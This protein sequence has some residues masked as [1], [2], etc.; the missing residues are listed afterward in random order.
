MAGHEHHPSALQ[1]PPGVAG[2]RTVRTDTHAHQ[3]RERA[4][5][6][7]QLAARTFPF[8]TDWGS[9]VRGAAAARTLYR[10]ILTAQERT[11]RPDHPNT[12]ILPADCL[13]LSMLPRARI[14]W[15]LATDTD[16]P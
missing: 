5:E 8:S 6:I 7:D 16:Q 14:I 3:M 13:P 11:L 2:W 4:S 12:L 1:G 9:S 15:Q 10:D